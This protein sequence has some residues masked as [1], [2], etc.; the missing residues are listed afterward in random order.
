[1]ITYCE[2]V[3]NYYLYFFCGNFIIVA[4]QSIIIIDT[5]LIEIIN[6][7]SNKKS[8]HGSVQYIKIMLPM[9]CCVQ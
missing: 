2:N 5:L 7:S 8:M 9:S 6:I 1:M 3:L 4:F